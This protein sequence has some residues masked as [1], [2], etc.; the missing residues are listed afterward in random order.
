MKSTPRCDPS[1]PG[2]RFALGLTLFALIAP[3]LLAQPQVQDIWGRDLQARGIT[4]VDWDGYLANPL[5]QLTLHP[6]TNA[7]LPGTLAVRA[8]LGRL[9][10]DSPSSV[11]H[12]GPTKRVSFNR[13]DEV[14]TVGIS[15]FPDRAGVDDDA[16][17][18]LV[19]YGAG[20][21]N[22]TNSL[23]IHVIDQDRDSPR[24]FEVLVNFDQDATG[25]FSDPLRQKLTWNAA[26]DWAYFFGNMAL[27]PVPAGAE[28]TYIWE[29]N[30]AG[31]EY[32]TNSNA[33][34]GFLLYAYGTQNDLHRSGGEAS[35]FGG[36]QTSGGMELPLHRSGG[37]E[38]EI[39]GNF[40]TLGWLLLPDDEDWLT[41]GNL[42][43]ETNDFYSIAHHEIGHALIFN[44]GHPGFRAAKQQGA[45]SSTAVV[46]YYG[47]PVPIDEFD[48]LNGGIDPES[49]QGAFGNEYYGS[50]PRRRWIPTKLDL[51]CAQE[52]GYVL[53]GGS[54][55]APLEW[56]PAGNPPPGRPSV[57]YAFAFNATGGVP[58]Y[59]WEVVE[60]TLPPGITLD[61]FTG[62]LQGTP[63][64]AGSFP[65]KI[66][67]RDYHVAAPG[68]TRE[69]TLVIAPP[70]EL[71]LEVALLGANVRVTVVGV[72]GQHPILWG[73]ADLGLWTPITTNTT[74]VARF[75]YEETPPADS[76]S[77]YYRATLP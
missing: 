25:V 38:S 24:E 16:Q 10:F 76:A 8:N 33:Y 29:D 1:S 6:P 22:L 53:R 23:P 51:L 71:R 56:A 70:P 73:A 15:V 40:N 11:T 27:D 77:R 34:I 14:Q 66:R 61:S 19:F 13:P 4:L 60:G 49:G 30:F 45:F 62:T 46:D 75:V 68:I 50:I 20:G 74:G 55:F 44:P 39:H 31:G 26:N 57:P 72:E 7:A 63:T 59:N 21:Q 28:S 67:V 35:F 47:G 5:I 52:V 2:P 69:V 43:H 64:T 36:A 42:G 65:C 12:A 18:T 54:A 58:I 48:H 41:S 37:F 9:Y 17:L 3:E 32:V